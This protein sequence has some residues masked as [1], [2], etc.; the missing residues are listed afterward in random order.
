MVLRGP[1]RALHGRARFF[2]KNYLWEKITKN[3]QKL[4]QN[5]LFKYVLAQIPHLRNFLCLSCSLFLQMA[6]LNRIIC[7]VVAHKENI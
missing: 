3:G 2:S 5:G 7:S 4:G 6:A 1:C